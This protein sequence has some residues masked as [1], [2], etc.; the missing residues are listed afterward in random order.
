MP[1]LALQPKRIVYLA[2]G[3]VAL[4]VGEQLGLAYWG[5]ALLFLPIFAL[6]ALLKLLVK[7]Q[8]PR[9]RGQ[10]LDR[11]SAGASLD[12]LLGMHRTATFLRFAA[13]RHEML[14]WLGRIFGHGGRHEAASEA[15]ERALEESPA[16]EAPALAL[17]LGDAQYALGQTEQAERTYR[18]A[19]SE[20]HRSTR[21][22]ANLARIILARDGDVEEAENYLQ[23]AVEGDRGGE[24]R[25]ELSELLLASGKDDDARWHLDLAAE[26]LQQAEASEQAT[27]RLERLREKLPA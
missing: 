27:E 22:C 8:L 18:S 10:L 7:R 5:T 13:P 25:L 16:S 21:A 14:A 17:S 6:E 20:E 15:Y 3:L 23:L 9:F 19:L 4:K 26:E 12:E 24:L 11:I 2:L 1:R